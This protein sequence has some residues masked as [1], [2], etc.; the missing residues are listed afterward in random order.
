MTDERERKVKA[1]AKRQ[2]FRF[3]LENICKQT[4]HGFDH[5]TIEWNTKDTEFME[6]AL[7]VTIYYTN[8]YSKQIGTECDSWRA[9]VMDVMRYA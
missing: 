4:V 1:N 3:A 7:S 6:E 2:Q 5:L 9:I 8:G